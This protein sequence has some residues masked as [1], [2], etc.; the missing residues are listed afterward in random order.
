MK[1]IFLFIISTLF[2]IF[3]SAQD[4]DTIRIKEVVIQGS[5]IN[6]KVIKLDEKIETSKSTGELMQ[7]IPGVTITKRSSFAIEPTINNYKYDQINTTINGGMSA[8]NS[9]PNRMDPIT[10]RI[11]PNE[12]NKIEVV[13]GPFEVRY[14]QIMG[15]FI[16]IVTNENPNFKQFSFGGNIASEYNFNGNGKIISTNIEVGNETFDVDVSA[17]YRKFNNYISGNRTEISSAYETYGI[18]SGFGLNISKKQRVFLNYIYSEAKDI[19]HAGLPMDAKYDKSNM[20]SLDYEFNEISEIISSFKI[21]LFAANEDH[22]M[23]NEYRP[24]A[25]VSL[26]NTPVVSNDFGGRFIFELNPVKNGLINIGADFKY[27]A[28]DGNKEVTQ[29]KNPCT[30]PPTIFNPPKEKVF[31]VWQNSNNTDIGAFFDFNYN[32]SQKISAKAGLRTDFIKSDI[33]SPEQDFI[34]LYDGNIKPANILSFNYF[35]KVKYNLAE[36]FDIELSA[37]HGT[38]NPGL[39]EQFINHFTVGLDAYEYVGNPHL[40]PESNNQINL[41]LTKT[42]KNFFTYIDLFYSQIHNYIT[43]VVDTTIPRKFMP[44]KEPKFAK[45]FTNIKNAQQFGINFRTKIFFLKHYSANLDLNYVYA[46]NLDLNDPLPE[47]APFT[48]LL[49]LGYK[50]K[51]LQVNLVNEFQAKQIRVSNLVGER[52]SEEFTV[53]NI[54]TSYLFFDK[55]NIGL[56]V[57]NI[58]DAN[59][60][61]HLSR[62]YKNMDTT[63]MF[64]EPGRNFRLFL[65]YGF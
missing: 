23:T 22:L 28:K 63:S 9:C 36:N 43:A 19:M 24:N 55:L 16:N 27:V 25:K 53:F 54:N 64:Y 37:G 45:R 35:A 6:Y 40:K 38:R 15:G 2:S 26:A 30:S 34:N 1:K 61:R 46:E 12:I 18:N 52:E 44:C 11:S 50:N 32:F 59:Y 51:N 17:N 56:A 41:M 29:F 31:E 49:T 14:G 62:P 20:F 42:H 3:L 65:K 33:K 10:T 48:S 8:S 7:Q 21:K 58:F 57:D 5:T 60:Y 13:R 39:L 4:F 47:T